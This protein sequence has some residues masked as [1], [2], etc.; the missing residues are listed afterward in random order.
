MM[1]LGKYFKWEGKIQLKLFLLTKI[2]E[3]NVD[4][5]IGWIKNDKNKLGGILALK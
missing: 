3:I 4:E 5:A 2:I 1:F